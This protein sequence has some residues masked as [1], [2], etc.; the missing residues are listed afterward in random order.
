MDIR[1]VGIII[2]TTFSVMNKN[3]WLKSYVYIFKILPNYSLNYQFKL[4][5]MK[6]MF[7][8]TLA[9]RVLSRGENGYFI[10]VWEVESYRLRRWISVDFLGS[11]STCATCVILN[12]LLNF[13]VSA[14]SSLKVRLILVSASSFLWGLNELMYV[15]IPEHYLAHSKFYNCLLLIKWLNIFMYKRYFCFCELCSYPLPIF[16]LGCW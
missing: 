4:T 2:I 8:Q 9:I 5:P 15:K 16:L 13:S 6:C 3:P 7:P 14:F 1:I 11:D 10:I 12:K